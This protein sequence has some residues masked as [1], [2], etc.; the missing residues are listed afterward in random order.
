MFKFDNLKEIHLEITNN[1]QARCPMCPRNVNGGLENPLIRTNEWSYEDFKTIMNPTVLNQIES[2]YFCGNFGDPM[3]NDDVIDMCRYAADINP[4]LSIQFHTNGGARKT[5]WWEQLA[6]ALPLNHRVIFAIDGLEDTHSIYRVDTKYETVIKN[7]QA[8]INAGGIAEWAFIKFKHN[9]HQ[10][11]EVRQ[12]AKDL[13]FT[14][15]SIKNS[16]RFLTDS[17][18]PVLDKNGSIEYYLETPSQ[19]IVKLIDK[20]AITNWSETRKSAEIDCRAQQ[21]NAIYI[22]AYKDLYACCYLGSVPFM[23]ISD[24][25]TKSVRQEMVVQHHAMIKRLGE[26]NT[27]KRPIEDIINSKEYQDLWQGMWH[28]NKSNM[29]VSICGKHQKLEET[30]FWNQWEEQSEIDQDKK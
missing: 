1:C 5:E 12:R 9:E 4:N 10:T 15:L 7:A 23:F 17:K 27:L 16:F 8:F 21:N 26:I 18:F 30:Q 22:D 28:T 29:C 13:G 14:H 24:D 19:S 3:M 2:F 25:I 11:D 20:T 6:K